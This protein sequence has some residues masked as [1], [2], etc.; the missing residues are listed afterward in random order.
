MHSE[1]GTKQPGKWRRAFLLLFIVAWG[2][3]G[4]CTSCFPITRTDDAGDHSWARQTVPILLGRKPK[5]CE[6]VQLL[7]DLVVL[8]DRDTVARALMA[9]DEFV[10]HWGEV[11]VDNMR[12]D[13]EGFRNQNI[14]FGPPKGSYFE[15]VRPVEDETEVRAKAYEAIRGAVA[16]GLL[17]QQREL[18]Y[19]A[20]LKHRSF[21]DFSAGL[22][23]VDNRR[24]SRV[25][26]AEA[27][28]R[29]GFESA[30]EQQGGAFWFYQPCR[31]NLLRRTNQE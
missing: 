21:E 1:S 6:E 18:C 20:P 15:L 14:C 13:R 3:A 8:T 2:I 27:A 24:R 17:A 30:A 31:L 7:T 19:E 5:G 4:G 29:A 28:L 10:D 11:F 12:V 23:A 16:G 9:Q 25:E 22:I 26:A